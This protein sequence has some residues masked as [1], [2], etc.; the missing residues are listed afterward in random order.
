MMQAS[1]TS[2]SSD[3]RIPVVAR[4][5]V[6]WLLSNTRMRVTPAYPYAPPKDRE[7]ALPTAGSQRSEMSNGMPSQLFALC[8]DA[9]EPLRL[10]QLWSGLLGWPG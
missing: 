6:G 9:D 5:P 3:Q 10:A 2:A 1:T 7:G 8:F 4:V